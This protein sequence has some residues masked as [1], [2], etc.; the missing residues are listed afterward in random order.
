MQNFRAELL[1]SLN[2]IKGKGSFMT[3]HAVPF[4]FPRL[5]IQNL[6]EISFPV[7]ELQAKAL[8][9]VARKAPFGKGSQTIVDD[10]VRSAWEIDSDKLQF[11]GNEWDK[12]IQGVLTKIK[13]E[14]GIED[15]EVEANLYKMLIYEKGD[16][17]LAH[18]DSEKERGMF[19]TLIIGLPSNHCGGELLIRF[20]GEEK[21]V[22]F[23]EAAN[24]YRIPYVAFYADCEHEVK[25]LTDGYRVCLVYNLVQK[26]TDKEIQF[27]PLSGHA[28][29]LSD[30]L[31]KSLVDNGFFP[32]IV[33]LGHQYTPENFSLEQLKL[34]DRPRAEALLKAADSA[35]YYAKMCLVTSY[36]TGSPNYDGYDWDDEIDD[37]AEMGEVYDDS[38]YIEHWL[39][40]GYPPLRGIQFSEED[41][42][43]TFQLNEGEPIVKESTGYMGNYGPDLDHWYH[44]GAV[45]FWPKIGHNELLLGQDIGN[46]LE[47]IGYYNTVRKQLSEIETTTCETILSA[48]LDSDG[49]MQKVDYNVIADWLIGYEDESCFDKLGYQVLKRYFQKI[50]PDS[51]CRLVEAYPAKHFEIIFK[52]V[53]QKG[54][55]SSL[56]HLMSIFKT[57]SDTDS[58][59]KIVFSQLPKLPEYFSFLASGEN[60]KALVNAEA[61]KNLLYLESLQPQDKEWVIS[62]KSALTGYRKRDYVN[63]VLVP[64]VL[65]LEKETSLS[66]ALFLFGKEELQ[67]RVNNKPQ[68]PANWSRPVPVVN[69]DKKL[70]NF[71]SGFLQSA[72]EEVLD[73]RSR[74][75]EREALESAIR[76]VKIDLRTE[77]IRQ[78]SPH[79]LRIIKTQAAY[80]KEM[81]EWGE[82]VVLLK[83]M[84]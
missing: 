34:N 67:L 72:T 48:I 18:R 22:H 11:N 12:L 73:F 7:N 57:L 30:I 40:E 56:W 37:D 51:W 70:W 76:K 33:L 45:I 29:R 63:Y 3:S 35:G 44:Y 23:E 32:G 49:P 71:L 66:K 8:I 2:Q 50:S 84:I 62:M 15:F 60:D 61:L 79:T 69:S 13:P 46:Q 16:F 75:A 17:F 38:L 64:V 31:K 14:L 10:A 27:E 58:R 65:Q 36:L 54:D 81:E 80:E 19:G 83:R 26:K 1:D 41:L 68:S 25:P 20:D 5:L 59:G 52:A 78:G 43:A 77:T 82:D 74:Q 6:G 4:V 21:S 53:T 55:A 24:D 42:L 47:W 28:S 9:Q 39:E